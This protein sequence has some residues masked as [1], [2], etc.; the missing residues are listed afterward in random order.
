MNKSPVQ[1]IQKTIFMLSIIFASIACRFPDAVKTIVESAVED[2]SIVSRDVYE[3]SAV[4]LG[5]TPETPKYPESAVYEVCFI[6]REV[7]SVR[8]SDG[9]RSEDKDG[10]TIP[11]GTYKGSIE[12]TEWNQEYGLYTPEV[13][14][15][16]DEN[17][18]IIHIAEDGTV[19]GS[20]K[21]MANGT[22]LMSD[23]SHGITCTVFNDRSYDGEASGQIFESTGE[24]IFEGEEQHVISHSEGCSTGATEKTT[25]QDFKIHVQVEIKNE[26]MYGT[27]VPSEGD[28]FYEISIILHSD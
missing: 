23:T 6:N 3:I 11:T 5:Q 19:T 20:L 1:K 21:Y 10:G 17:E 28:R 22:I 2:C 8:M 26:A 24:I 25:A 27:S 16:I 4:Q 9:N 18:V 14:G 15:T 7:S 13:P 12:D